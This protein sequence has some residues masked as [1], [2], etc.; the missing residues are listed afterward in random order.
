M[1]GYAVAERIAGLLRPAV[2]LTPLPMPAALTAVG[3]TLLSWISYGLAFWFLGKGLLAE[4]I[5]TARAAIGVFAAGY[6]VGLLALF[7]PGGV[8]VR[9]L[10]YVALL[11][12]MIGSAGALALSI[13][14]RLLLTVTEAGAALAALVFTK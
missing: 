2:H 6:I 3:V 8:G 9:E 11:G 7:A 1:P 14:S 5:P 10:V 4:S 13:A 12:P